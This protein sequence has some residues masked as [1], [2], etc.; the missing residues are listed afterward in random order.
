LKCTGLE[1][2]GN[3]NLTFSSQGHSE[4]IMQ[5]LLVGAYSADRRNRP[6]QLCWNCSFLAG[7][8]SSCTKIDV[9]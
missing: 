6:A 1:L 9:L 3:T 5:T 8:I 4:L 2:V 7:F